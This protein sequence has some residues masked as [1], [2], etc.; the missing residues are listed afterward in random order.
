MESYDYQVSLNTIIEQFNAGFELSI[1]PADPLVKKAQAIIDDRET[2]DKEIQP[3]LSNW[4]L[5]RIGCIT[6]LII[7]LALWEL[8]Y[9]DTPASIIINEAIELAKCFAEQDAYKFVN[10]VLD[11]WVSSNRP[12]EKIARSAEQEAAKTSTDEDTDEDEEVEDE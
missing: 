3:L 5:D 9:T 11:Q 12:E 6:R 8:K 4:R 10:G 1:D 2:L 7:R